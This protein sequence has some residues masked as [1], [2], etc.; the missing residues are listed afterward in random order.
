MEPKPLL[1]GPGGD[2]SGA[3]ASAAGDPSITLVEAGPSLGV[4]IADGCHEDSYSGRL[5]LDR[6]TWARGDESAGTLRDFACVGLYRADGGVWVAEDAGTGRL[7]PRPSRLPYRVVFIPVEDLHVLM[8]HKAAGGAGAI[9]AFA[10][11]RF[12]GLPGFRLQEQRLVPPDDYAAVG[13]GVL[14]CRDY[15]R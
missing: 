1:I 4:L 5:F 15:V 6:V 8:G 13:E 10:R 11:A 7:L 12:G 9:F 2:V 14:P 3:I